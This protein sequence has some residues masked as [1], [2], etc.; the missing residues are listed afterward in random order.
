M[1]I[2]KQ[3]GLEY[4][5]SL[6]FAWGKVVW[7]VVHSPRDLNTRSLL[8]SSYPRCTV[9]FGSKCLRTSR[10]SI[11]IVINSFRHLQETWNF[12][13]K[14]WSKDRDFYTDGNTN[15][16]RHSESVCLHL[17]KWAQTKSDLHL[18]KRAQTFFDR[19]EIFGD[20]R[21]GSSS[22]IDD[23]K[24]FPG[25]LEYNSDQGV[26]ETPLKDSFWELVV[27]IYCNLTYPEKKNSSN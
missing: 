20:W 9:N 25:G 21:Q 14:L 18:Y 5:T 16:H 22:I 19:A 24:T 15:H 6:D 27:I 23:R 4:L 11:F 12:I 3:W 7:M 2:Q 10:D 26:S 13:G 8:Y 1:G 17:Y